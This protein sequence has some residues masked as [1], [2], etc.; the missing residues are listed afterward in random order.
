MLIKNDNK[1][2]IDFCEYF[3]ID[4][5][6]E[7]KDYRNEDKIRALDKKEF[8]K[9]LKNNDN[10]IL[11]LYKYLY[12]LFLKYSD[13]FHV[14]Y[15]FVNKPTHNEFFVNPC[16]KYY[17][18]SMIHFESLIKK[19]EEIKF[20]SSLYGDNKEK[21]LE[22]SADVLYN[23]MQELCDD[24]DDIYVLY[25]EIKVSISDEWE[26]LLKNSMV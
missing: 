8:K 26:Y 25:N 19:K 24:I 5:N 9:T 11:D 6:E 15:D 1:K 21:L 14:V 18:N 4:V 16:T 10:E 13:R 2:N 22:Q 20:V 7:D 3:N 23:V 12:E 17:Y